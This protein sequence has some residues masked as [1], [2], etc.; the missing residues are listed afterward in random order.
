MSG[1][2][3]ELPAVWRR[4]LRGRI[5]PI[6]IAGSATLIVAVRFVAPVPSGA[7]H[8]ELAHLQTANEITGFAL[9]IVA[10]A[11]A[12]LLLAPD[13]HDEF[14]SLTAAGGSRPVTFAAGRVVAGA[15]GLLI[16]TVALGVAIETLDVG[17]AYQREEA[18]HLL[19]L[20]ANA[21]PVFILALL[22][23][24]LFGRGAGLIGA[25]FL[26]AIGADAAYQRGSFADHFIEPSGLFWGEQLF[27]W[28]APRP[29]MDP[30]P[31]IALMDESVALQQ[32]PVREGHAVW[33]ADLIQVS[34]SADLV[35]YAVYLAALLVIFYVVCRWRATHARS[36]F[37]LV[38][39]WLEARRPGRGED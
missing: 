5:L 25:F 32:F 16:A 21:V 24:C 30:L 29:L 10:L 26:L 12:Y 23:T 4:L 33:G 38:P 34:G 20:F 37:R 27:A 9:M 14:E 7:V 13:I 8:S 39:S 18:V 11:G 31:G 22:L 15:G 19:V 36:R 2:N 6:L 17:G 35:Q 28:L 1:L 3:P